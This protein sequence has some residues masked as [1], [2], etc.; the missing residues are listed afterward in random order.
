[1]AR[2]ELHYRWE[3]RLRSSPPALWPS[4]ADTNRFNR[5]TGIPAIERV[6]GPGALAS[7]RRRLRLHRLGLPIEWEEDPF[8]WV[9]PRR[10]GVVRRYA[11][12]P[13]TQMRVLVELESADGG[14][15][16][17][18]YQVWARPRHL[19][20][21]LAVPI[22]VGRRCA[23]AFEAAVRRYDALLAAPRPPAVGPGAGRPAPELTA[24]ARE[25]LAAG[26]AV[27]ERG[28]ADPTLV[29]R[30]VETLGEADDLG[31]TRLRPYALADLW[32]ASR[33]PV[34]ELCLAATRAGLL[35]LRWN[36]LCPL[37]RGTQASA[38]TLGEVRRDVHCDTCQIDFTVDLERLIELTFRPNPAIRAVEDREFC[39]GGPQVTPHVVVQQLLPPGA[40]RP[41]AVTLELGRYRLRA[42]GQPGGRLVQ[43]TAGGP[44]E[45]TLR[46]EPGGWPPGEAAVAPTATLVLENPTGAEQLLLF[47]RLAW[48]DQ[49]TTAAEVIMLQAFRDLFAS[50]A[51]RPGERIAV[52][53][54]V[55]VFTD[56]L[57]STRL[58][59]EVGD[60]PAFGRVMNHFEI[61]REAITREGGGIV[62]TIGDA[63]MA[64][65]GRPLAAL[66]AVLDA[67]RRLGAPPGSTR[68]LTLRA[69]IHV[70]PCIAVTLNDRLDYFG[71]AV[72]LAAR[73]E[74]L[75]TGRDVVV[76]RAVATDP[77]V[78]AWLAEAGPAVSVERFET[79]L[80]GF[81]AERFEV[82]R[83]TPGAE[84][85]PG[86]PTLSGPAGGR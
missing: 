60:A 24:G 76:S 26:R 34:L 42:L 69:G 12:G 5:D 63:V 86:L 33:R 19:L 21:R 81:E 50:E 29:A 73:L 78:A 49:A 85:L 22:E 51:L 13:L 39:I 48:T 53:Q 10:F 31:L 58:Y 77:E 38:G 14:G 44:A 72:N 70:G 61:L 68:P 4:I 74:G 3:W 23:R 43:V 82:W 8:E 62:K 71:S 6:E 2:Q 65:F 75:S 47:E 54:V 32:D 37:C 25:R 28:G 64:A 18:V 16:R 11:R 56:L 27:L 83:I 67:Q 36:L 30:L 17:V 84:A 35:D 55:L 52:G 57:G 46:L 79:A 45:A 40:R 1:M 15:T 59:R 9:W 7:A 20:G 41:V 80:R 66:R